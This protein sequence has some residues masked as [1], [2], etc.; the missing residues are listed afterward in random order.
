[1]KY[2]SL[3]LFVPLLL[4]FTIWHNN[5]DEAKQLAK[6]EHKYIL[7][8]FS[9]S[10]WCGPCIRLHKEIL[11]TEAFLKFANNSLI[12]V[13]ADFPRLKKINCLQR[14]KKLMTPLLI[15]IILTEAFL[16]RFY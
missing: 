10:D 4:S 11:E 6:K 8:N 15:N 12:L 13:N 5:L 16:L 3:L 2:I 9:G 1:M 14:N 7:L